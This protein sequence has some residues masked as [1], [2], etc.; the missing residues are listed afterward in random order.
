MRI[1]MAGAH[2][3]GFDGFRPMHPRERAL[4]LDVV[5]RVFER[6]ELAAR[7]VDRA[8]RANSHLNSRTRHHLTDSVFAVVRLRA[9]LD[10]LLDAA[11]K[12]AGDL[13]F[14]SIPTPEQNRLRFALAL[15]TELGVPLAQAVQDADV[16]PPLA[17]AVELAAT[18]QP[19]WPAD[20]VAR[21]AAERSLPAWLARRLL[22]EYGAEAD[23]LLAAL[24]VRGPAFVR[25]N[26]LKTTR[27]A[28]ARELAA[29]GVP[30]TA[31][32]LSPWALE[33]EKRPNAFALPSFRAGRFELQ[34][35]GS[36]LVAAAT[37]ASPGETVV[38]ACAGA[39]GK[40]LALAAMMR[41]K[42][43]LVA[44]DIAGERMKDLGPRASRAGVFNVQP[45]VVDPGPDGEHVLRKHVGRADAVLVDAPCSGTGAWRRNPDARWRLTESAAEEYPARQ[46]S[47]LER[48]ARLVAPGGRL[49][50]A[51]CSLLRAENEEVVGRFLARG[52]F[53]LER[54]PVPEA[55][56]DAAGCLKLLP[57]RH[58]TDGFFTAVLRRVSRE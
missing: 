46:L 33:L 37:G 31:G 13:R 21:L 43:R 32:A 6:G 23:P 55:A 30:V 8:V 25:A 12:D 27:A 29:D 45:L 28:L 39:G 36:Q 5:S 47:I 41:N 42:G 57:H 1:R 2:P 14:D 15:A 20:P 24:N 26:L 34:D 3:L 51:T 53:A 10:Y 11:L 16:G 18:R 38:D 4:V 54:A 49:V 19:A 50:Y 40:T 9:R 58:R 56:L 35:E 52:D 7:A 44:C 48:Y 17:P 22:A